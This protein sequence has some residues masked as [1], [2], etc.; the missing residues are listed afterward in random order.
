MKAIE[1]FKVADRY[2]LTAD[3]HEPVKVG[4]ELHAKD[5]RWRVVGLGRQF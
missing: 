1:L 5:S 2:I 4:D 3:T